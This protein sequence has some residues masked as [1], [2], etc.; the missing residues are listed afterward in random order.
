MFPKFF[1]WGRGM[2]NLPLRAEKFS[3]L[4]FLKTFFHAGWFAYQRTLI[5]YTYFPSGNIGMLFL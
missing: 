3:F 5:N 4:H 1:Q 2:R